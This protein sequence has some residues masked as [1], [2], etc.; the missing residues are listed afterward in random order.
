[1]GGWMLNIF[2]TSLCHFRQLFMVDMEF[3]AKFQLHFFFAFKAFKPILVTTCA[4]FGQIF[5]VG[6]KGVK[7]KHFNF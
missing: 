4:V 6:G 2:V 3:F 7:A 1:M 5:M